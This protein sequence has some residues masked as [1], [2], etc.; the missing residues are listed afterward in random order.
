MGR[1][2]FKP[3]KYNNSYMPKR[4]AEDPARGKKKKRIP[5][6]FILILIII[7]L[8]YIVIYSPVFRIKK[9]VVS[10]SGEE[11]ILNEIRIVTKRETN[12]YD[13]Y[14]WPRD[15]IIL[16]NTDMLSAV[17][18]S[19]VLLDELEIKKK[20]FNKLEIN[21]REKVPQLLWHEDE[22]YFYIDKQGIVMGA[23]KF[24]DISFD[25]PWISRVTSTPVV[26]GN[27]IIEPIEIDFIKEVLA[28]VSKLFNDWQVTQIIVREA[29]NNR[30]RFVTNEGWYFILQTGT[31]IDESIYNL[32]KLLEQKIAERDK[33]LYIDLR[34][35]DRIFYKLK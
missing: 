11:N 31:A 33:L 35:E 12:G 24:E 18:D 15:N 27:L 5:I 26:V 32:N 1:K 23:V 30:L 2:F 17:I 8:I 13:L 20:F 29:G 6:L 10:G 22:N 19:Q 14:I 3:K 28:K 21:A 4:R 16:L 7:G 34:I 25:L 9:I